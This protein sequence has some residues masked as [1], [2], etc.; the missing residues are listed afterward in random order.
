ME[1]N[2]GH[3]LRLLNALKRVKNPP[4][5]FLLMSSMGSYGPF[6]GAECLTTDMPQTPN[7]EYG[8]SK[9]QAEKFVKESGLPYT[10]LCPTGV[11]GAGEEDYWLSIKAMQKGWNFVSG[12]APQRLSFVY[13]KDV[14]RA[15]LFLLEHP[16]SKGQS[17]LI[18]DGEAY[19]DRDFT[20]IVSQLL[21]KKVRE[22]RVPLPIMK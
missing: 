15:T 20:H 21:G 19:T 13:V 8:R 7:T 9:L 10:I 18:S 1:V 5:R 3:T 11:Y 17:Y 14:A 22:V 16:E 4:K 12:S 6:T 2:A